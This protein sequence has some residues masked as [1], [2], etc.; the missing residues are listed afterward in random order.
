EEPTGQSRA[1]N[2][3]GFFDR[4]ELQRNEFASHRLPQRK[5]NMKGWLIEDEDEPLEQEASD[6]E[7]PPP[8]SQEHGLNVRVLV[9]ARSVQAQ[10][11]LA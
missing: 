5:G 7:V 1:L 2:K 3:Y 11:E 6:K 10:V 4:P 9:R 8:G